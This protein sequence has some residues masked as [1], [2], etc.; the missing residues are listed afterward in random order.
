[1]VT[2][3]FGTSDGDVHE[4][5]PPQ[6]LF[7]VIGGGAC[8]WIDCL[9]FSTSK[10]FV[11]MIMHRA[12]IPPSSKLQAHRPFYTLPV[13]C[14][15]ALSVI[16]PVNEEEVMRKTS[17]PRLHGCNSCSRHQFEVKAPIIGSGITYHIMAYRSS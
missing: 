13:T 17:S 9:Y 6:G 7:F 16:S 11:P 14:A 12:S 4:V 3:L 5:E 2:W 10:A 1:M 15:D 8:P